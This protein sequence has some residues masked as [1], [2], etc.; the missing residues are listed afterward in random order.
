MTR[1]CH[2]LG[3]CNG[4]HCHD[5]S[6]CPDFD[7]LAC[8]SSTCQVD[9]DYYPTCPHAPSDVFECEVACSP[10]PPRPTHPFAPG[11]I[12]RGTSTSDFEY[13]NRDLPLSLRELAWVLGLVVVFSGLGGL[14]AG[15]LK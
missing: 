4:R 11:V 15:W 14:I 7:L 10:E 5:V 8:N 6:A 13:Y 3:V 12:Q 1:S 2:D 9:D